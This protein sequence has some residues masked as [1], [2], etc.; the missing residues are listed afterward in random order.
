MKLYVI[1]RQDLP[2]GDQATQSCHAIVQFWCDHPD[3]AQEW[4]TQSNT[5]ALLSVRNEI[6][7]KRFLQHARDLCIRCSEF[8]EPDMANQL[9][10]IT[11]EPGPRTRKLTQ[12]LPQTLVGK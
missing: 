7:L 4:F 9:T 2:P 5:L 1:T 8:R 11:L 12:R 3:M 6:E 10:A